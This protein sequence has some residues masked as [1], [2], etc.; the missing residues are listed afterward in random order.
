MKA[1]PKSVIETSKEIGLEVNAQ[2]TN[3]LLSRHQKKWQNLTKNTKRS[4]ENVQQLKY[5]GTPVTS[6]NM[7]QE[8]IKRRLNLCNACI[9]IWCLKT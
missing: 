9:V 7:I 4:V 6:R 5:L 2:K 3:M 1:M 8:E